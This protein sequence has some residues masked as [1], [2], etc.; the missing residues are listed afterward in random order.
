MD[1]KELY[2]NVR[3]AYRLAYEVQ[4]SIIAIVEHIRGK[5]KYTACAGSQLFSKSIEKYK[6]AVDEYADQKFGDSRWSWDYFPTYMYMYYFK[7]KPTKTQKCCFSIV[8]IMDDGFVGLNEE[9][10]S[11]STEKFKNPVDSESYLLFAFSIWKGQDYIWF[12]RNENKTKLSDEKPE[13]IRIIKAIKG[14]EYV[15]YV[16]SSDTSTFV[17]T[18]INL[19]LIG[20]KQ[21]A[22]KVLQDFAKLVLDKTGYQLLIEERQ[23]NPPLH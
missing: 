1:R 4:D 5:I 13:V 22:D 8:Q 10:A 6:P 17:V 2:Q 23:E 18:R 7:C 14:N 11:P 16:V 21:E 19:E 3:K 15:P 20:S 9:K 12:N